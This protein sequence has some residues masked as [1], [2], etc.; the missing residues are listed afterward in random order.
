MKNLLFIVTMVIAFILQANEASAFIARGTLKG[1]VYSSPLITTATV[2]SISAKI[3]KDSQ[4][5]EHVY[6]Y[7]T[8]H[9]K[10]ILKG[11]VKNS[12]LLVK[13]FGGR[14]NG[15]GSW[16]EE[17]IQFKTNEEV[18][19]FLHPED[20]EKNIWK[21]KSQSS[22]LSI[23]TT[24]GARSFDCSKLYPDGEVSKNNSYPLMEENIII[25]KIKDYILT[26]KG[27]Y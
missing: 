25:N 11:N 6:T 7:V 27:G 14:I 17:W 20:M 24:N 8:I 22:K 23:I 5:K 21:M 18:L 19:L 15:K 3:E 2:S 16:S 9:I 26:N 4:G 12:S 10:S 13:M 1:L